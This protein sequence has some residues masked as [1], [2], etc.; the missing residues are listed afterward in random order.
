MKL[1]TIVTKQMKAATLVET[2]VSL[3]IIMIVFSIGMIIFNR[4]I[5]SG[6]QFQQLQIHL[7]MKKIAIETK[8]NNRYFDET[9]SKDQYIIEKKITKYKNTEFIY[10]L[11]LISYSNS[12]KK[13]GSYNELIIIDDYKK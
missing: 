6:N 5:F 7:L 13:V 11:Q 2:I 8:T 3:I 10:H 12:N 1:K 9:F 4:V